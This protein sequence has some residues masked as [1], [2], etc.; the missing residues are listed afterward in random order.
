[1]FTFHNCINLGIDLQSTRKPMET[2]WVKL[3]FFIDKKKIRMSIHSTWEQWWMCASRCK[4]KVWRPHRTETTE[5]GITYKWCLHSNAHELKVLFGLH[6]Q[7]WEPVILLLIINFYICTVM[8][9]S[10]ICMKNIVIT[11]YCRTAAY[12]D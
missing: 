9:I 4:R 8:Q 5:E 11:L 3:V 1:M 6:P 7:V 10:W 12:S 2:N